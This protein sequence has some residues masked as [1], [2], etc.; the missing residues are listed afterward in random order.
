[1]LEWIV[2]PFS[3]GI[4]QRALLEVVII[5]AICGPLGVWIVLFR[6]SYAAESISHGML[7]GLVIASLAGLPFGL[8]AAAGL[9]LA[10]VLV[11]LASRSE[12]VGEDVAVAVVV[13]TLFGAGTLLALSPEVPVGLGDLLFGD[14]LSVTR[15]D[16]AAAGALALGTLLL[17]AGFHRTLTMSGFDPGSSPSLG[18]SNR[19]AAMALLGLLAATTLVAVQALGNLLVVAIIVGPAV[20][21]LRLRSRLPAALAT[22]GALAVLVGVGGLYVSHYLEI[23]AGAAIALAAVACALIALLPAPAP[24]AGRLSGASG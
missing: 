7:P 8:G 11:S 10:A 9:A 4:G 5:G 22:A 24:R 14:P 17:L 19:L 20:A 3:S 16:L 12:L 13:T 2:D 23:A 21:A 6:Q 1:M 18:G 15:S